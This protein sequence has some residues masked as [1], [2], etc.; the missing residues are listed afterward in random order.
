MLSLTYWKGI[1]NIS[2]HNEFEWKYILLETRVNGINFIFALH[3]ILRKNPSYSFY[4]SQL[5]RNYSLGR[6]TVW[7]EMSLT[8]WKILL[9]VSPAENLFFFI[10][11]ERWCMQYLFQVVWFYSKTD[12]MMKVLLD[13]FIYTESVYNICEIFHW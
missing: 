2:A 6:C 7:P 1:S 10:K 5:Q 12:W 8:E 11:H 13:L 9:G 3:F 4:F